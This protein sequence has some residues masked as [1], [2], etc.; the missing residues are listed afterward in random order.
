MNKILIT[1]YRGFIGQHLLK[2]FNNNY[3]IYLFSRKKIKT[4]KKNIFFFKINLFE[5][6]K[7][8]LLLRKLKPK[9][10]I[11]L[12]WETQPIKFWN[13]NSNL[14]WLHASKHLCYEF[15]KNGGKKLIFFGSGAECNFNSRIIKEEMEQLKSY[16]LYTLAKTEL[17]FNIKKI[18]DI[19]KVKFIW[20]RVFWVYGV[21]EKKN[22]LTS[23][24]I[25]SFIQNKKLILK[26]PNMLINIINTE[27]ICKII[28]KILRS[29]ITGIVNIA[30]KKNI[31]LISYLRIIL[32]YFPKYNKKV[33]LKKKIYENINK[34][35]IITKKLKKVKFLEKYN[36]ENGIKKILLNKI[37]KK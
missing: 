2:N 8:S 23:D 16:N 36:I 24:I 22:R 32:K 6:K 14:D 29:K 34:Y 13:K 17:Y 19:F 37:N 21:N 20:S 15:C 26:N 4:K 10:L 7:V 1:G 25:N 35:K 18:A 31:T 33:I 30:T 9:Y 27:D 11:H 5:K 28:I 3:K 12:A